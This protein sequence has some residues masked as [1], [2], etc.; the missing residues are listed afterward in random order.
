MTEAHWPEVCAIYQTGIDTGHATFESSPP[1][2]WELW[3]QCHISE[4]SLV[5]LDGDTVVGW[6]SLS[7]GFREAFRSLETRIKLFLSLPLSSID[8][9]RLKERLDTI[10]RTPNPHTD[11]AH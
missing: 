2:S 10:G 5:A 9:M 3:Q 6:A 11:D 1:S 8:R 7:S 4:L